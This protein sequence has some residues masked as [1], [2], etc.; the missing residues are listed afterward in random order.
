LTYSGTIATILGLLTK[1]AA[2]MSKAHTVSTIRQLVSDGEKFTML[3]AYDATFAHLFSAHGIE[4]LL[5]G[6][7]LGMVCQGR[8]STLP[9]TLDEMVYHTAAVAR[10]N[11]GALI[12]ADMP[13]NSY[14]NVAQALDSAGRLMQAGAQ[15]VKLEGG[16]WLADAV[17]AMS[18]AG[19]PTCLHLGLTPQSV[20]KFGGYKVQGRDEAS[21][22]LMINEALAL[23]AAG[24]DFILLECVPASLAKALTQTVSVPVIGIGAGNGTDGQ[25][26]VSY[27]MLGLTQQ[28]MAKFVK[29]YMAQNTGWE[30]AVAAY[31]ADVKSGQFP[32]PEHCFE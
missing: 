23:E 10:G 18:R 6:D 11:Q 24:A 2:I 19:I 1:G 26:L 15:M 28:R 32:A 14:G 21:A 17:T 5:V 3:T 30:S 20:N 29:N 9:V 7:S 8:S 16:A 27:D 31:I 22:Q 25:V 12:V 13:F 4:T